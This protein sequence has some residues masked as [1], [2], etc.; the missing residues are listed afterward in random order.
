MKLTT[1]GRKLLGVD[2]EKVTIYYHQGPLLA[3]AEKPDLADYESLGTFA[4]EIAK[5]GAPKGVM[6][7]TTAIA[8]GSFGKGRVWCF[9]PHPERTEGL[10][11]MVHR[12]IV[13]A[14]GEK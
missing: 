6:P 8:A 2:D 9:S 4:S 5:N 13:W 11:K 10:Q 14:A 1:N 12:S 7:G 3:P